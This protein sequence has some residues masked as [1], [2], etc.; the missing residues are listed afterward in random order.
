LDGNLK[1][2]G[3]ECEKGRGERAIGEEGLLMLYVV[4]CMLYV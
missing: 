3:R 1:L 2:G 4:C